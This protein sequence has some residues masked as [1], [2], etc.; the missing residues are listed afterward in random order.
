M[1]IW[2][3]LEEHIQTIPGQ[4]FLFV[5]VA[6]VTSSFGFITWSPWQLVLIAGL[7][8][9]P[10]FPVFTAIA[11][12]IFFGMNSPNKFYEL[13]SL[14]YD[15]H[16]EL[17]QIAK[18]SYLTSLEMFSIW[19]TLYLLI[20]FAGVMSLN[21]VPGKKGVW[22]VT[23]TSV[24][25]AAPFF[26]RPYMSGHIFHQT[27]FALTIACQVLLAWAIV[28]V[29]NSAS[30]VTQVLHHLQVILSPVNQKIQVPAW[31]NI[32]SRL[33][34]S[35]NQV[36]AIKLL[37]WA[38]CLG[39]VLEIISWTVFAKRLSKWNPRIIP[40]LKLPNPYL[41]GF[42]KYNSLHIH[43]A[44][45]L[46]VLFFSTIILIMGYTAVSGVIVGY[47][48]LAGLT[49]PRN[50]YKVHQAKN[51]ND[52][53]RRLHY[54]YSEYLLVFFY[55]PLWKKTAS[56][57]LKPLHRQLLVLF[58]TVC[59]GGW[60]LHA[61]RCISMHFYFTGD[62]LLR[63]HLVWLVYFA[64]IGTFACFSLLPDSGWCPERM[65]LPL[66]IFFHTLALMFFTIDPS[67]TLTARMEL[68]SGLLRGW[69]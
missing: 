42:E 66:I 33:E 39:L 58:L 15:R 56:W 44:Q 53:F 41:M 11:G 19:H 14:N 20:A 46:A 7:L 31:Q 16:M 45:T 17:L 69:P 4:I 18:Q 32:T 22:F 12:L 63:F 51:F 21:R 52:Y 38:R 68:L 55:H 35:K 59:F 61:S 57:G 34:I 9:Y 6:M 60:L 54:F 65:K 37:I 36:K 25:F 5:V 27:I 40:T 13:G 2:R 8:L 43:P 29:K 24:L 26:L 1:N 62:D 67:D 28:P 50:V 64:L 49:I 10:K 3:K 23:L 48:R 30:K 47:L